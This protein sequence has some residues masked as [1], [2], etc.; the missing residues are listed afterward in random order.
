MALPAYGQQV[1]L[2]LPGGRVVHPDG[3]PVLRVFVQVPDMV[4]DNAGR[5]PVVLPAE[6]ALVVVHG[7]HLPPHP[8]PRAAVV[9]AVCA[10]ASLPAIG[11]AFW[12][13]LSPPGK[14]KK[15]EPTYPHF[16]DHVAQ[17]LWLRLSSIFRKCS[18]L[19]WRQ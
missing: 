11:L 10:H 2:S 12:P 9:K 7:Q 5:V 16:A 6:L 13:G 1:P 18:R 19:Q 3:Q 4:D 14:T 15:P 8:P 17:A